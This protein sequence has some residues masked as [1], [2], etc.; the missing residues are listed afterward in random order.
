[1]RE[2]RRKKKKKKK[3][4][5]RRRKK[6]VK[7]EEEE[8]EGKKEEERKEKGGEGPWSDDRPRHP[9]HSSTPSSPPLAGEEGK[10]PSCWPSCR[11]CC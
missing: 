11:L 8:R 10:A 5:G 4:K 1:M 6:K 3:K 2:E 7:E 9:C